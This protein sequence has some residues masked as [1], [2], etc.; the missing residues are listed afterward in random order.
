MHGGGDQRIRLR[1]HT[2]K[3]ALRGQVQER[4]CLF[5]RDRRKASQEIIYS[6]PGLEMV[7][8]CL[9]RNPSPGKAGSPVHDVRIDCDDLSQIGF[10]LSGHESRIVDYTV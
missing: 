1:E 2:L 10:P 7:H 8:Q 6:M 4:D 5:T 3:K 9:H